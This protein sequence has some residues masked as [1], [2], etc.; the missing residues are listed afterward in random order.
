ME[1]FHPGYLLNAIV[2]AFLGILI[3]VI[4]FVVIDKMTPY[5]LW[6]E[7]VEDKNVALAVLIGAMSIGMC[8]IIAA[9]VH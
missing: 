9:A 5:H 2:Y 1:D 7:I 3:F 6:K 4:A 8:I